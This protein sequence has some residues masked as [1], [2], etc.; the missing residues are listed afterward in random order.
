VA[1]GDLK[2]EIALPKAKTDDEVA[3]T[4]AA[5]E[6]PYGNYAEQCEIVDGMMDLLL[7]SSNWRGMQPDQREA[8]HMIVVKVS[9]IANGDANYRDSWVDIGGYAMLVANRL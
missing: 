5:R 3:A 9:R 4:I 7:D 6:S 2:I 8:L 1:S